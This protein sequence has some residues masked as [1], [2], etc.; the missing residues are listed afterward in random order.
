MHPRHDM[1]G[2]QRAAVLLLIVAVSL[3]INSRTVADPDLWGHVRFGQDILASRSLPAADPYSYLTAGQ[4]WIN[5]E[6]A[7]EAVF[8]AVFNAAGPCGLVALKTAILLGVVLLLYRHLRAWAREPLAAGVVVLLVVF[9]MEVG[10]RTIRPQLLSYFFFLLLLLVIYAADRGRVR[11][12][13]LAPPIIAVWAN[14]HGAFLAGLAL[15]AAWSAR[16][17]PRSAMRR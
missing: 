7:S 9:I 6:W 2:R 15:L 14:F 12:L 4:P 3:Y 13:W 10:N 16:A 1:D 8:A 5:H 11:A 17:S